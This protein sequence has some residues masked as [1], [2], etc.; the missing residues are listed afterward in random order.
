MLSQLRP[1]L[2]DVEEQDVRLRIREAENGSGA[3]D[4]EQYAVDT[5]G[6]TVGDTYS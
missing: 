2:S 4:N 6:S 5:G 1:G 3:R